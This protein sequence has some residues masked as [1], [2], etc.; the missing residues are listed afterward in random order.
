M[1]C[2]DK[3]RS[4]SDSSRTLMRVLRHSCETSAACTPLD[5]VE[6]GESNGTSCWEALLPK[7]P[8]HVA[9]SPFEVAQTCQRIQKLGQRSIQRAF[10]RIW[11]RES[12]I[13]FWRG[14]QGNPLVGPARFRTPRAPNAATKLL[15]LANRL[16][17]Q[18]TPRTLARRPRLPSAVT[19]RA[20]GSTRRV[21][22]CA[23]LPHVGHL[24]TLI[25]QRQSISSGHGVRRGWQASARGRNQCVLSWRLTPQRSSSTRAAAISPVW[26]R[27]P[28][29]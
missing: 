24:R 21:E 29:G 26:T 7:L 1:L 12:G 10:W 4:S 5:V 3:T 22:A 13:A 23:S 27:P 9:L 8:F 2:T 6:H 15:T 20:A 25:E 16:L 11:A 18:P 17:V 14:G 28:P 19:A